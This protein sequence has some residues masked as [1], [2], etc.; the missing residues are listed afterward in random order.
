MKPNLKKKPPPEPELPKKYLS[1]T[2]VPGQSLEHAMRVPRAI[3]DEHAGRPTKP[4]DVAHAMKVQPGSGPFRMLC[5]AA[6]AYGLTEGGYNADVI[7]ITD[8]GRRVI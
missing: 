6:I 4:L 1:Q 7:A 8:L 3:M 2:D 5:G